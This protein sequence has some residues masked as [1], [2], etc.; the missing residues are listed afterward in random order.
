MPSERRRERRPQLDI[1]DY[2]RRITEVD[3]GEIARELLGDR[4]TEESRHRM[5]CDCPNHRSESHRS[6][7]VWLDKQS[8]YCFGCGVGGDV[9]QLVEFVRSGTV[10]RGQSG[11]MPDSHRQARDF[12][13]VRVALPP[14]SR[15]SSVR[16]EEAEQE[17]RLAVRVREALTAL[18]DFYHQLLVENP[19]VLNWFVTKYGISQ[20]T[21]AQLKIGYADGG[22]TS[23]ARAL[24]D[25]PGAF[26]ERELIATGAFRPTRQNDDIVQ[27]FFDHRIV[28]PY[29]RH[30]PSSLYDWPTN[31]MDT[32]EKPKY[33][34][35]PIRN[36]TDHNYIAR[37]VRNDVLYNEDLFLRRPERII[38]TEGVTDCISLIEH[39]F[40]AVSPVTV[41]IREDDWQRLMPKFVTIKTVFVC[42]DNEISEAGLRGALQTARLLARRGIATRVPVL[43]LGEK[44]RIAREKLAALPADS[45]EKEVLLAE[46]KID[47]NGFFASG[48]TAV[49]F[50]QILAAATTPI[51]M[52][53]AKLPTEV[54][55]ADLA[56]RLEPILAEICQLEPIQ[57]QQYLHSIVEKYG[58]ARLPIGVLRQQMR[59]LTK[60]I[61]DSATRATARPTDSNIQD[62]TDSTEKRPNIQI[63]DRQLREITRDCL[64]ALR[65]AND[66]PTIFTRSNRLVR[67]QQQQDGSRSI[68]LL[69]EDVV[70]NE[71]TRVANFWRL[72][73]A[74][75]HDCPPTPEVVKDI[76]GLVPNSETNG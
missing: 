16:P 60:K 25:G 29:W 35:L 36:D 23:A 48:K 30:G 53:I 56:G 12:L 73:K 58:K 72:I 14:L 34:K 59:V 49:D 17:H 37:C 9:L 40:P 52:G 31:S 43:P 74:D 33:K 64:D 11:P 54:A 63:N 21:I 65:I 61:A 19:E 32:W 24:M 1:H 8:W 76:L 13:A 70:C 68:N 39:G 2:Y 44:Q 20:E 6:L 3:I 10:T 46:A 7:Q 4:I 66:P 5:Y 75:Y 18:A 41:R 26:S 15:L 28:F 47:V 57:Q 69:T 27:P 45:P 50:E 55:D 67:I 51:E 71:L 22:A 38:V 62:T 42:Q